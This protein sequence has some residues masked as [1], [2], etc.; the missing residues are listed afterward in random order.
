MSKFTDTINIRV[1][2]GHGGAG[3]VSF[4]REKYIAK[5]GPDGG[6]GGDGGNVYVTGNRSMT[7]LS[8][9]LP[10]KQ[11]KAQ[12]GWYG[13]GRNKHGANGDDLTIKVPLGTEL[14]NRD[15]GELICDVIDDE[16]VYLLAEGGR[17]GKGN[18]FFKSSTNQIPRFSQ[19]GEDGE[20]LEITLN[21]KLIADVGIV[22]LP[23]AGKSTF[24]KTVTNAK[25]K[26]GDYPFT[27]LIPNIGVVKNISGSEYKIADIP[28]IIEG[29]HKGSG[30]GLSFLRHIERV[31]GL[32]YFIDIQEH[33]IAYTFNLLKNELKSYSDNMLDKP[34]RIILTKADVLEE[35]IEDESFLSDL[36]RDL[37]EKNIIPI[38]SLDGYNTDRVLREIESMLGL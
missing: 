11:Y 14:I 17:G 37:P 24:L 22:G 2:A 15:T 1:A 8:S 4:H 21:L 27:T 33:D 6:D 32:L 25:P 9:F 35:V 10:G 7:N 12:R 34:Y 3:S 29:A 38:S 31:K 30:L 16:E 20:E 36:T 28:G 5:G 13:E 19:P 23:N 18:A 26:V